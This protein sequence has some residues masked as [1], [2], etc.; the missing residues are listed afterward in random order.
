[1]KD[2]LKEYAPLLIMLICFVPLFI[3][4][5]KLFAWIL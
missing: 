4:L 2:K 1:M 5:S 3:G